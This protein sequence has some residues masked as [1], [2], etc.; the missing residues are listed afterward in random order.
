MQKYIEY[1]GYVVRGNAE[2]WSEALWVGGYTITTKR[3]GKQIREC[4]EA[5]L[6]E[7]ADSAR[8]AAILRGQQYVDLTLP[9]LVI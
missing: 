4:P 8:N 6:R 1:K 9:H 7:T 3:S 5:V 2:L